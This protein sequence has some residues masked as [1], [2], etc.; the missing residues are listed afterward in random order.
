MATINPRRVLQVFSSL[1]KGGAETR[2]MQMYRIIDRSRVQF[3]FVVTT[4]GEQFYFEEI[5]K[6]GG[7]IFFVDSWRKL[8]MS[9]YQKQWADI[10]KQEKYCAVHA[11]TTLDCG[12]ALHF[13]KKA[14]IEIRVAHARN[15]KVS[16]NPSILQQLKNVLMKSLTRRTSTRKVACSTQAAEYLFGRRA[17]RQGKVVLL[18]DATDLRPFCNL[19]TDAHTYKKKLNIDGFSY[20]IGTVGNARPVKNHP[21][22]I[23]A[24]H[25]FLQQ[26]ENSVL[27]IAG[28]NDADQEA[29]RLVRQFGID[30]HVRFLGEWNE[31][32]ELLMVMDVFIMPSFY[33]G[34]PSSVVEA[35]AANLPCILSDSLTREIDVGIGLV[36]YIS[37][38][39]PIEA[40][41]KEMYDSCKMKRPNHEE[42]WNMIKS[43]G[44]DIESNARELM[45]IYRLDD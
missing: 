32:P 6:L 33:E 15:A 22:L 7:R 26:Y 42:T 19:Q 37:L 25:A 18:P 41:V 14:G 31:I 36:K 35:Q 21:F 27:I 30:D 11:H 9:G 12:I 38:N 2:V 17:V 28:R 34:G 5:R 1:D 4:P 23:R 3:D 43:K 13:A 10:F 20:V 29:K 40:W 39:A 16:L 45:K 24:F 8:G 44:Y